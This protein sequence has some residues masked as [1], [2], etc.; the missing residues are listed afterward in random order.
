MGNNKKSAFDMLNIEFQ[1]AELNMFEQM[2]HVISRW[3]GYKAAV[4]VK[5]ILKIHPT[6]V[7]DVNTKN[8]TTIESVSMNGPCI[9]LNLKE[10]E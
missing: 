3:D 4:L 8:L 7:W 10:D 1:L 9:Q 2:C 5:E 6:M